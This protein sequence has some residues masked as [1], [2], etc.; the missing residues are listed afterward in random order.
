M[1]IEIWSDIMCPFCYIGKRHLE[2]ALAILPFKNE[3][4]IDW[5]S[6]QLN[7]DY[8]NTNNE[9]LFEYLANNKGMSI[10][11]AKQLTNSVS[12]MAKN[13]GLELDFTNS[14][15]ANSFNAHRLLQLAKTKNLQD[16]AE[17]ALFY[18]HFVAGKD[19]AQNEVLLAT[20]EKIGLSASDVEKVLQ[21]DDFNHQVRYDVYESQQ[22]GVRGVP[23]FLLDGKYG[24]SGAQPVETF[25]EALTQ[26]YNERTV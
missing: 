19:V 16:E 13:V 3:I 21:S 14:I 25:V 15:P 11:Q 12:E 20:G 9:S 22:I 5:K 23:F 4:E 17:E 8:H 26:T 7:P 6:Y 24:L 2:K 18:T 10:D 1:K